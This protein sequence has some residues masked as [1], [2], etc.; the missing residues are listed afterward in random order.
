M[1]R[2]LT[3]ESR[4]T[5]IAL[6]LAEAVKHRLSVFWIRADRF[7]NFAAD[8]AQILKELDS[9]SPQQTL[10]LSDDSSNV[11]ET[12]RR[13]LEA[14]PDRWLLIL[15]NADDM[16]A[17][18]GRNPNP[19][20]NQGLSISQFL[21]RHGRMLITTRDRRFQGTVAAASNG[22]KI[23]SMTEEEATKLLLASIPGYLMR[24]D[25][26][27]PNH[28]QELVRELGYLPLAIAQAAAN[29]VEQ[30]L[31]LDEY[32]SF[33]QN[34][35]ERMGLM[36]APAHDFQTTDPRNASQSVNVTWQISFDVLV[37]KHP[38]SAKLLMYIGCLLAKHPQIS[39]QAASRV[40][41]P[42]RTG[43]YT[44]HE[45]AL[46]S[47]PARRGRKHIWHD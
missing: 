8:Y 19:D 42:D 5:Q 31:T 27:S 9:E 38:L 7:A 44:A 18:L 23:D 1:T 33:F 28:A 40:L 35:K 14:D 24:E 10:T 22:M 13:R 11:L 20:D 21:P 29:I 43:I 41:R 15:D 26:Q 2:L 16:D 46:E 3:Y 37:E 45:E 32:V 25:W 34:K 39:H 6:K 30:Q 4:K 47:F 12:T 36:E 17:F